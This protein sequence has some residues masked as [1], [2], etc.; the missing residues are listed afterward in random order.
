MSSFHPPTELLMEYA[1]G[2]SNDAVAL[3]VACH[4]TFCATCRSQVA[5]Y[6]R[7]GAS[8]AMGAPT[9]PE[10][11]EAPFDKL[12][13]GVLSTLD[14]QDPGPEPDL[15]TQDP[16]FPTPL[17][18]YTG[19]SNKVAW[20]RVLP[21]VYIHELQ[22]RW[23]DVPVRL[24]RARAGRAIPLHTHE[25]YECDLILQGGLHD[26]S[27]GGDFERGD[28]QAADESV[29][30]ELCALPGEDCILVAFN[31]GRAQGRSLAAKLLY[32]Y[33]GW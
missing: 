12:L 18:H 10:P 9:A 4:T 8:L 6:E 23:G 13:D 30:H 25:G 24:T 21:G 16:I 5:Q 17:V 29:T 3:L 19:P 33:L 27:R 2:S 28:V 31:E 14:Q 7:I 1:A 15:P 26:L 20:K 32:R 11:S 22:L